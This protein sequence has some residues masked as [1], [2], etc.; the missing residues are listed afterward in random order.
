MPHLLPQATT[1]RVVAA[2]R[3]ALIASF[4]VG[5]GEVRKIRYGTLA[6]ALHTE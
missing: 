4:D 5:A 6:R 2:V 3:F 1:E